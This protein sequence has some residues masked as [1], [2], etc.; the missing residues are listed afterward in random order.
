MTHYYEN[1]N[2]WIEGDYKNGIQVGTYYNN[3]QESTKGVYKYNE[4]SGK[5][6]FF[7][8]HGTV[9]EELEY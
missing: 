2:T 8:E 1:G 6:I 3:V 4:R 5:Q 9:R 7:N